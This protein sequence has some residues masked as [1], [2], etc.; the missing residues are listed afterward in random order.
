MAEL[1][2]ELSDLYAVVVS[3]AV[4]GGD[5][6]WNK[7]ARAWDRES[8]WGHG[9]TPQ[10]PDHEVEVLGTRMRVRPS[11]P[12]AD[13]LGAAM[14]LV[15]GLRRQGVCQHCGIGDVSAHAVAPN[16]WSEPMLLCVFRPDPSTVESSGGGGRR[17]H[18]G[19]P[20]G[21][22]S[23][24]RAD[25]LAED[26]WVPF[27]TYLYGQPMTTYGA[28]QTS[29]CARCTQAAW[30]KR[31]NVLSRLRE[32]SPTEPS[33]WDV[34]AAMIERRSELQERFRR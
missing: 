5:L 22:S 1:P 24:A 30:N 19:H 18:W 29:W 26:D 23:V 17:K 3:D 25:V 32:E 11:L 6:R 28:L 10:K 16:I 7:S 27:G 21:C 4:G 34:R 9:F 13:G 15:E 31:A 12:D 20:N 2:D 14:S 33:A 8:D